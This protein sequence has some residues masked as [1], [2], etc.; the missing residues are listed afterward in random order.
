MENSTLADALFLLECIHEMAYKYKKNLRIPAEI[1]P[2]LAMNKLIYFDPFV[3]GYH[4]CDNKNI[5]IA[6]AASPINRYAIA[7]TVLT[8]K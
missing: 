4:V 2:I 5:L 3:D 1:I 8:F 7:Y 6:E